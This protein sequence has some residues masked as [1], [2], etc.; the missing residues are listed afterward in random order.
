MTDIAVTQMEPGHFGIQVE[1]G[2]VITSHRASLSGGLVDDLQL[3]EIDPVRIVRESVAFLLD[4]LPATSLPS[5]I[6]LDGLGREYPDYY[7]EL[8][9]R[10][11]PA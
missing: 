7:D 1:E 5:E 11:S 10:L 8:R 4:R 2:T 9:S 6:A 3:G